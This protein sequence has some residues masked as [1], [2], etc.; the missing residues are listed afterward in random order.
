MSPCPGRTTPKYPMLQV[1]HNVLI[2]CNERKS[3]SQ[4]EAEMG[5]EIEDGDERSSA[6]IT[7]RPR[8][9]KK[10]GKTKTIRQ[11]YAVQRTIDGRHTGESNSVSVHLLGLIEFLE[12]V[13]SLVCVSSCDISKPESEPLS[14]R[15]DEFLVFWNRSVVGMTSDM[16][17]PV[18]AQDFSSFQLNSDMQV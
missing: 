17:P 2:R 1:D 16:T 14:G 10:K 6:K 4:T 9:K 8:V 11:G 13:A 15:C 7:I 5:K 3:L 18:M 12:C